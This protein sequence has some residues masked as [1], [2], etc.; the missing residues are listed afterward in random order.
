MLVRNLVAVMFALACCAAPAGA[1]APDPCVSAVGGS[2]RVVDVSIPQRGGGSLAARLYAPD[3]SLQIA[4]C[5]CIAMLPGGGAGISSVEWAALRLAREGYVVI[6]AQPA[7]G[8]SAGS[9]DTAVRSAVDYLASPANP[10]RASGDV[11]RVGASGWSLGARALSRTQE[12]DVRLSAIVAWDN[13]AI[14]ESGDAGSP[15][16]T[17]LPGVIRVPRVP[18]MGQA[19]DGCANG[20]ESK[21]TAFNAWRT[22]GVPAFQVVFAGSNHFWWSGS[23]TDAQASIAHFYT[24]AWFDRW[25]KHDPTALDRLLSGAPAGVP[26]ATL[27]SSQFRSGA[28]LDGVNCDDLRARCRCSPADVATE[29]A[30]DPL[31]AGPDGFLTG[32]DFDAF[33]QAFFS[34]ARRPGPGAGFIADIAGPVGQPGAD[35]FVTGADLDRFFAEF[36][37]GCP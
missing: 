7:S 26:A 10:L 1:R 5:P 33:I 31:A 17:N 18:A 13:L 19:S 37:A 29:G 24:L 36:F 12:D 25:L 6:I 9:Y 8:G 16:C 3:P 2:A 34:A 4:P 15:A 21:K 35:G 11:A 23:N 32:A 28:F 14:S 22:A 30:P 27:L 20:P